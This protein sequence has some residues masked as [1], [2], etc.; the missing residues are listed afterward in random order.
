MKHWIWLFAALIILGPVRGQVITDS[1]TLEESVFADSIARVNAAAALKAEA[2]TLYNEGVSLYTADRAPEA[3]ARLNAALARMPSLTEA[4]Y[5]RAIVRAHLKKYTPALSDLDSAR[6]LD[7]SYP[8]LEDTRSEILMEA[9]QYEEAIP[10][11]DALASRPGAEATVLH[12]RGT[13]HFMLGHIE[14]AATDFHKATTLKPSW[15]AAWNDLASAYR[16]MGQAE[17]ALGFLEQAIKAEPRSAYII[18]NMGSTLRSLDRKEEALQ[19][20]ASARTTDMGYEPAWINQI[21]LLI[22]MD[23]PAEAL[24]LVEDAL[25]RFP[26]QPALH[27][28]KGVLLRKAGKPKEAVQALNEALR[29]DPSYAVAYLNRAI[30]REEA[31]DGSGACADYSKA[32]ELGLEDAR[33]YYDRECQ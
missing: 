11:L 25:K 5:N 30:A 3:E 13:A 29:I 15:A 28:Q 4:W 20:Y 2:L 23:R 33:K 32:R 16:S 18:N 12:R 27:N 8:G 1:L 22:E 31:G 7:P 24:P 26:S 19:R 9:G 17:K 21:S 14:Q 10:V 6:A